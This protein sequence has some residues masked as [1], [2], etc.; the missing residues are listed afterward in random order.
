MKKETHLIKQKQNYSDYT[1]K[2][3][4]HLWKKHQLQPCSYCGILQE[5][6]A[7]NRCGYLE[8]K[9]LEKVD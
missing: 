7:C 1:E 5:N 4:E 2:E 6:C 8:D 9:A 3:K